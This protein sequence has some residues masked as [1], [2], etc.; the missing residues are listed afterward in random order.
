MPTGP[1]SLIDAF[2]GRSNVR[3]S[4]RLF[5]VLAG[6]PDPRKKCGIRFASASIL[7]V[8]VAAVSAGC[9]SYVAIGEWSADAPRDVV[10]MLGVMGPAPSEKTIRA[11]LKRTDATVLSVT[12]G[13][14]LRPRA[15]RRRAARS[16]T[17]IAV[18]GKTTR[19]ARLASAPDLSAPHLLA[20]FEHQTGVVL[21]QRQIE[22]KGSEI[23]ELPRLL[24]DIDI[25]GT[26]VIADAL[27]TQRS[28]VEYLERRG[29][30]WVFAVR[31]NQ[32]TLLKAEKALPWDDVDVA[33]Q[34]WGKAHGR[35]QWRSVRGCHGHRGPPVSRAPASRSSDPPHQAAR[36]DEVARRDRLRDHVPDRGTHDP[37]RDRDDP[38]PPLVD[39]ERTP[40]GPRRHLRR[41]RLTHPQPPRTRDDGRPPQPRHQP[42]PPRRRRQH[43]SLDPLEQPR[44]TTSRGAP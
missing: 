42:L 41:A 22:D 1:S 6:V 39:R 20:A 7:A 14:W 23:R 19:G 36:S 35:I 4:D 3:E 18:D 26:V 11:H 30:D 10:T 38:A 29:A 9:R 24:E 25:A 44:P 27:R 15:D 21:W 17:V 2:A 33:A 31:G 37:S 32:P 13:R 8:A 28:H 16:R 43:R 34:S 40:L 12:I 5:S